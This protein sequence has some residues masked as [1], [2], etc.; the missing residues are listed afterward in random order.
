MLIAVTPADIV[1]SVILAL[2]RPAL[3]AKLEEGS[4]NDIGPLTFFDQVWIATCYSPL[5][6]T[7]WWV[8]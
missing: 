3:R 4:G 8:L 2:S 1:N 7:C 6:A 5:P